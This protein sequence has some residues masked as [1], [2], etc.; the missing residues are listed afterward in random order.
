[1]VEEIENKTLRPKQFQQMHGSVAVNTYR[2]K[3]SKHFLFN[4]K[5][6]PEV[7][8]PFARLV[9]DGPFLYRHTN[10]ILLF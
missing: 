6:W 10:V 9:Q 2:K 5:K 4:K 8:T 3:C 1:M 7:V